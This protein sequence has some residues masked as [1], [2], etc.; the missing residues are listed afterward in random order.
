MR[1]IDAYFRRVALVLL[2]LLAVL[3]LPGAGRPKTALP[4]SVQR[5]VIAIKQQASM[6]VGPISRAPFL[7]VRSRR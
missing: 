1:K 6:P 7:L 5:A 4:F 2:T 3:Q